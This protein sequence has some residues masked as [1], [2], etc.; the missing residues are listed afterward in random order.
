[1]PPE[2]SATH[3][4]KP[5]HILLIEVTRYKEERMSGYR[6][7]KD[8]DFGRSRLL[9]VSRW[10]LV[11]VLVG[12]G[13][14]LL[15]RHPLPQPQIGEVRRLGS[16]QSQLGQVLLAGEPVPS[17]A[18]FDSE[19]VWSSFDDWE[20]AVAADP[21]SS[22]VYHLTTRYDGPKPCGSCKL[23]AIVFHS[24][25]NGGATWGPD[26]FV[27]QTKK[28]Q[29]DPQIEVAQD[30]TIF[31]LLLNDYR[32]G[33]L[34][35]K[36]NNHGQSWSEPI[37]FTGGSGRPSWNDR[38]V[39]AISPD[40]QDVYVAFNASDSYIA[41]SHDG[42]NSFGLPVKTNQDTRYWFHSAG[43]VAPDGDVYFAT[44][45]YSQ[46]Y[47]GVSHIGV[48]KSTNG[49]ASW[50]ATQ[51]DTSQEMPDCPWSLG[52]YFGFF[53]PSIGL[54]VDSSGK[55]LVAYHVGDTAGM[56]QQM[57]VRTS[58]DGLNWSARQVISNVDNAFPAVA[59]GL[60]AG[61]FRVVWQDDR[62]GQ[63]DGWNTWYRETSN[64]GTTWSVPYRL[65][66]LTSGAPYKDSTGY[67]FPYGDYL[68]IAVDG[69]GMNHIIWGEGSSYTG[70]GGTWYTRG[71]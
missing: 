11:L 14:A 27:L 12:V 3:L 69:L 60:S 39:L 53:G 19:R 61:D 37:K 32:P 10:V 1:M 68:E 36:S 65:S 6:F 41:A 38:P 18:G 58:T 64:G 2:H 46:T 7:V 45:D 29:N 47:D 26:S 62:F 15:M 66:D 35:M 55:I 49:G 31:M 23:P 63:T 43:A 50:T 34:F 5:R 25:S 67:Q 70:P 13:G 48:L 8:Y 30:G 16:G 51:I 44:A 56:P 40:G 9:S 20:P 24:S 4:G 71:D 21:S 42:G 57:V 59:A 17:L 54:A 52:C 22:Y 28:T 33:V